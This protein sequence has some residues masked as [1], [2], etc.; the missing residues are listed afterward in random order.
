MAISSSRFGFS[1]AT[2]TGLNVIDVRNVSS[3]FAG[4]FASIDNNL[5]TVNSLLDKANLD[6]LLAGVQNMAANVAASISKMLDKIIEGFKNLKLPNFIRNALDKL[7]GLD[8]SGVKSFLSNAFKIGKAFYCANIGAF[9]GLITGAMN[10]N[11]LSGV[12]IGMVMDWLGRLLGCHVPS[13]VSNSSNR[14]IVESLLGYGGV[15]LTKDSLIPQFSNSYLNYTKKQ[16]AKQDKSYPKV[17]G[18]EQL[19]ESITDTAFTESLIYGIKT[20][21]VDPKHKDN[22]IKLLDELLVDTTVGSPEQENLSSIRK[23]VITSGPVTNSDTLTTL[24]KDTD[25]INDIVVDIQDNGISSKDKEN[26]IKVIDKTLPTLTPNTSE[27]DNLLHLKEKLTTSTMGPS[28]DTLVSS[29][30]DVTYINVLIYQLNSNGVTQSDRG[31]YRSSIED[32]LL[33]LTP[34]TEEHNNLLKL[35]NV[36]NNVGPIPSN[37]SIIEAIGSMETL[38]KLIEDIRDKGISSS[39]KKAYI[40]TLEHILSLY[41]E[42]SA[43]YANILKLKAEVSKASPINKEKKEDLGLTSHAETALGSLLKRVEDFDLDSI[44]KHSLDELEKSILDKIAVTKEALSKNQDFKSRK[45]GT[46]N[47]D[48]FNFDEVLPEFTEEE[49]KTMNSFKGEDNGEYEGSRFNGMHP[50]TQILLESATNPFREDPAL[51]G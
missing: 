2:T 29:S 50:T 22:Y 24:A 32:A 51:C 26:Y 18:K 5:S 4:S 46:G 1:D 14:S 23:E 12:L 44:N 28:T 34:D 47:F 17:P 38:N 45:E 36:L 20:D 33:F 41:S 3:R 39:D 11:I 21:G 13:T 35:L 25:T 19:L 7:M 30:G 10:K 15:T 6:N 27:H 49:L 48:T 42:I 9:T 31:V 40:L 8:L 37:E 43:E 16:S